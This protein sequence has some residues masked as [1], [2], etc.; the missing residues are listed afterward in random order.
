[1]ALEGLGKRVVR[2]SADGVPAHL[3]FLPTS[4]LVIT[5]FPASPPSLALVVDSDSLDRIG[6]QW[7][8]LLQIPDLIRIDHHATGDSHN[9]LAWLDPQ[10]SSAAELIFRMLKLLP[11]QMT[12]EIATCLYAGILTDTGR[13]CYSNTSARALSI[14]S[15]LVKAGAQPQYI[16]QMVYEQK[17]PFAA[18]L[19]GLALTGL[20]QAERG[21]LVWS[22]LSRQSFSQSGS[23]QAETEGIIDQLRAIQ[24]AQLAILFIEQPEGK[25]RV[26][27]RSKGK[28]DVA[29]MAAGFGGGG[30]AQAAG[31]T[32]EGPLS[33]AES[34]V[35]EAAKLALRGS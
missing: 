10:A 13:F 18:K 1:M 23:D 15:R 32:L 17:R 26:S 20:Q 8:K 33:D 28:I 6:Q 11:C 7:K 31:C 2:L 29:Q 14:S 21:E 19:L 12:A 25:V 22:S 34:R 5:R 27:L 4:D 24:G 16:A 35:L 9:E 30:H 3:R